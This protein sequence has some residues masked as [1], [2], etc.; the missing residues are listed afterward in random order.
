MATHVEKKTGISKQSSPLHFMTKSITECRLL[1]QFGSMIT[2]DKV[3]IQYF[4]GKTTFDKKKTL[5]TNKL[6]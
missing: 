6:D 2:N 4:H 1:Q 3:K 5:F